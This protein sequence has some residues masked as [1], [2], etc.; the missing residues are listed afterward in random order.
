MNWAD[1]FEAMLPEHV[2]LAGL[3]LLLCIEIARGRP[4]D[5]RFGESTY[6]EGDDG[7]DD[8]LGDRRCR[9]VA[10]GQ[11]LEPDA[12]DNQ[13]NG[14]HDHCRQQDEEAGVADVDPQRVAEERRDVARLRERQPVHAAAPASSR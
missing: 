6:E 8:G 3:V 7:R 10:P 4:R 5:E 12:L 14:H 2:L 1:V 9:V 11:S 13:V